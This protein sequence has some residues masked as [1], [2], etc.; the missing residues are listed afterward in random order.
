MGGGG[1]GGGGARVGALAGR[2]A[3][4]AFG[5]LT[6]SPATRAVARAAIDAARRNRHPAL[7]GLRGKRFRRALERANAPSG[8]NRRTEKDKNSKSAKSADRGGPVVDKET[9][10]LMDAAANRAVVEALAEGLASGPGAWEGEE[11]LTLWTRDA[12]RVGSPRARATLLLALR[13]A[14]ENRA[15]DDSDSEPSDLGEDDRSNKEVRVSASGVAAARRALWTLVKE[16]WFGEHGGGAFLD[17]DA[18]F[19]LPGAA[20]FKR[21]GVGARANTFELDVLRDVKASTFRAIAKQDARVVAALAR[22]AARAVCSFDSGKEVRSAPSSA[23]APAPFDAAAAAREAF[24]VVAASL[25]RSGPG[26]CATRRS[27]EAT[28]ESILRALGEDAA[29]FLAAKAACDPKPGT[30]TPRSRA[31]RWSCWPAAAEAAE[32]VK[33]RRTRRRSPRSSPPAAPP[34]RRRAA[35][36]R[37][38]AALAPAGG[39]KKPAAKAARAGGSD[40]SAVGR[41]SPPPATSSGTPAR[42]RRRRERRRARRWRRFER[43]RGRRGDARCSRARCGVRRNRNRN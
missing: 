13:R 37:A 12:W 5:H 11:A 10:A 18:P 26:A 30:R 28:V 27:L 42:R 16:E 20:D 2:G 33:V 21:G 41:R 31:S 19:E 35:A 24:D 8:A 39:K 6:V 14:A 3:A 38:V 43:R 34:T 40:V 7:S 15:G 23:S 29:A 17:A 25:A 9:R 1:G 36:A 4:L 32:R 22:S